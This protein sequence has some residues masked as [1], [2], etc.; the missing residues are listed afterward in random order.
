MQKLIIFT[1]FFSQLTLANFLFAEESALKTEQEL[2]QEDLIVSVTQTTEGAV[3]SKQEE[4]QTSEH[5]ELY[6][7]DYPENE[8]PDPLEKFNRFIFGFNGA[9]DKVLLTPTANVYKYIVP[10]YGRD[11]V[12]NVLY[13]FREPVNM[14]N[15]LLQGNFTYSVQSFW[16]FTTN[17]LLG[18]GGVLDVASAANLPRR[19]Q[20][21][22]DTLHHYCFR[23]GPYVVLPIIG[24][25]SFRGNVGLVADYFSEPTNYFHRD[26]VY[27][28]TALN[29]IDSRL[30]HDSELS[31][32]KKVSLDSYAIVRSV[33]SQRNYEQIPARCQKYRK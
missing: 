31:E 23:T 1:A 18:F 16:R 25:S 21:F 26:F 8:I 15:H 27:V 4:V 10:K 20:G 32:L 14:L 19:A 11:R 7:Q 29:I 28:K 17:L 5:V 33:Y 9:V 2:Q 13:N 22:N 30:E 24:P 12:S 6:L 3:A